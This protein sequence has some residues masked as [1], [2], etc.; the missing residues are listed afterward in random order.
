MTVPRP[1]RRLA[2]AWAVLL[3]AVAAC[4]PE[5]TMY[6]LEP[7]SLN[8]GGG[9]GGGGKGGGNTGGGGSTSGPAVAA[10]TPSFGR[11]GQVLVGVRITGS[12]YDNSAI[13]SWERDGLPDPAI[14]VLA[15]RFLTSSELEA[16]IEIDGDADVDL[17]DVSV[18]LSSGKRG[19]GIESFEVT[20]A[21]V[22]ADLCSTSNGFSQSF[23]TNNAGAVVGLSCEQAFIREPGGMV[24]SLGT[25]LASDVDQSGQMVVGRSGDKAAL[26]IRGGP[27]GTWSNPILLPANGWTGRANRVA[28]DDAGNAWIIGGRVDQPLKGKKSAGQPAIWLREGATWRLVL[29]PRPTWLSADAL[30]PIFGISRNGRAVSRFTHA[31]WEPTFPGS[32]QYTIVPLPGGGEARGISPNGEWI[33][34]YNSTLGA[35]YWKRTSLGSWTGPFA[36]NLQCGTGTAYDVNDHGVIVGSGCEGGA[37]WRVGSDGSVQEIRLPGFGKNDASG[38]AWGVNNAQPARAAGNG[39]KSA[40]YWDL[41]W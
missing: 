37:A 13:A 26:W 16:D 41:P 12:G 4:S 5:P 28:S 39:T 8:K 9:K 29:L 18:T 31:V 32:D 33:A 40:V 15:T 38:T 20:T 36:L 24:V 23:A 27:N 7:A 30:V 1:V 10:V 6:Q 21:V 17:Y 22:A 3:V 34:G 35:A 19:I 2:S 11:Q 25:Q 14:R